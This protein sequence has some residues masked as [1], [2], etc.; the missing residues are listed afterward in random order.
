M[1]CNRPDP[2]PPVGSIERAYA[3]GYT[4]KAHGILVNCTACGEQLK[5]PGALLIGPPYN[6]SWVMKMH[7]C[8]GCYP[9]IIAAC[10]AINADV[11]A[12]PSTGNKRYPREEDDEDNDEGA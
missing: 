11:N 8:V 7:L 1:N 6:L 10:E 4:A 3:D 9:K 12:K 2:K 5:Q